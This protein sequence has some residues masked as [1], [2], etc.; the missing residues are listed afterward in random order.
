MSVNYENPDLEYEVTQEDVIDTLKEVRGIGEIY[1][2]KIVGTVD[3]Q[4]Y[5]DLL[6]HNHELKHCVRN[7]L[8][9]SI[10]EEK[11]RNKILLNL[12]KIVEKDN[13]SLFE[14]NGD[15]Q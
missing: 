5:A 14:Y 6:T 15:A 2:L 4:C 1:A 8:Y 12:E 7:Q 9:K 3:A 10:N 11:L 13:D